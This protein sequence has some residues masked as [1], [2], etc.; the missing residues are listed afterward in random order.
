MSTF[1][2]PETERRKRE[3]LVR[4]RKGDIA[5]RAKV[6][7]GNVRF[8]DT[9]DELRKLLAD[10]EPRAVVR[11][12]VALNEVGESGALGLK[13]SPE[14]YGL[15]KIETVEEMQARYQNELDSLKQEME[16]REQAAYE[17]GLADGKSKGHDEGVGEVKE[18]FDAHIDLLLKMAESAA[19]STKQYFAAVEERLVEFA[20]QIARKVVGD[21][22]ESH[23]EIVVR[24]AGEA[25]RQASER[26][27]VILRCNVQDVETLK[28]AT[29]DLLAISEGIRDVEIEASPRIEP[30]GVVL[31]TDAGSIDATIRTMLDELHEALL[32]NHSAGGSVTPD[33]KEGEE[34][35]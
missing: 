32:P 15:S 33:K 22:V 4:Q 17:K 12:K 34:T 28:Q 25:L 13:Y 8:E 26:T 18:N 9:S 3:K 2:D 1:I 35:V 24:L 10:L 19:E 27:R 23:R 30:G 7:R 31:E 21:A 14:H 6:I 29:G 11:G 16:R 5:P 20:M